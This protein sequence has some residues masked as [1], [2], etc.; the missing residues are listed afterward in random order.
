MS[1][2]RKLEK[3][4]KRLEKIITENSVTFVNKQDTNEKIVMKY[5]GEF[6]TSKVTTIINETDL[7]QSEGL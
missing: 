1:T 5:D 4:I 3:R 2:I 7:A 6:K